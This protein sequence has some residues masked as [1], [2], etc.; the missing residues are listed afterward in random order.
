MAFGGL[1]K[2][3]ERGEIEPTDKV[4]VISTAHGLKFTDFKIRYHQGK[5]D[6]FGV[7]PG[8]PNLPVELPA[9]YDKVRDA[10]FRQLD[11]TA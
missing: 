4:V 3:L 8:K 10:I 5:L 1:L 9:D 6:A 11:S 7:K 2:L